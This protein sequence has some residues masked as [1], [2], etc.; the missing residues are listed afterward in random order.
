MNETL[1]I[2]EVRATFFPKSRV[3]AR[4][5]V[6]RQVFQN[7]FLITDLLACEALDAQVLTVL[8]FQ[9]SLE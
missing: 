9:A 8:D 7:G 5:D 1:N 3:P 4:D 6:F 2:F